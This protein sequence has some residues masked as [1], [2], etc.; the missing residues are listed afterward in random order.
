MS[1][2]KEMGVTA[3]SARSPTQFS[4]RSVERSW[5]S[6]TFSF[7]FYAFE[8]MLFTRSYFFFGGGRIDA[9]YVCFF[10]FF[11]GYNPSCLRKSRD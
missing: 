8:P 2:L 6:N 11:N 1:R 10:F 3:A 7:A 4:L 9:A 5:I